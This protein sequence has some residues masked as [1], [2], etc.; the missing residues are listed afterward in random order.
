MNIKRIFKNIKSS[1]D[2]K[3]LVTNFAYLSILQIA[4]YVFPILTLPYLAKVLGVAKFGEIAFAA[5]IIGYFNT[6][7]DWGFNFTAT[8]DIA[9]NRE[10]LKVVS[11]IF[12]NVMW[13][14]LTI[15]LISSVI[16]MVLLIFVPILRTH[17]LLFIFTFLIVPSNVL[18]PVW[19]FQGLERMKYITI[20]NLMSK[21]LFTV[22]VFVFI[23]NESD[24]ILQP[25][26]TSLGFFLSGAIS[27]YIIIVKW[28]IRLEKPSI[29]GIKKTIFNSS[30]VFINNL[31][32]NLYNSFSVLLL[33]VFGGSV[34]NGLYSAGSRL[35]DIFQ[36]FMDIFSRTFFPFLSRKIG[37]HTLF[38]KINLSISFAISSLLFILS[39]M[40][41]RLLFGTEFGSS[42]IVLRIL[43]FSIFFLSLSSVYGT[44]FMII[45]GKES[46]L[47]NITTLCSVLGF[48]M[49]IPLVYYFDYV[50]AAITL[51][52]TRAILG[53]SIAYKAVYFKKVIKTN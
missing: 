42:I 34:S 45:Q 20:L 26:L 13:A 49:A 6:V 27:L 48:L 32:P 40:L 22:L 38:V 16:F 17:Y 30:D 51:L 47:R 2:A 33:G 21:F 14:R 36:Q 25:L 44:N 7:A 18:F 41:I 28:K 11:S 37:Y 50:G 52:L 53:V 12:S 46:L 3:G 23:K 31:M 39:P 1:K 4:G 9:Q 8:R 5:S 29:K 15:L 35:I 24:Y 10:N 19:L 43:S